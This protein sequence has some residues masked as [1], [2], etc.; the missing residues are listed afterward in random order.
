MAAVVAWCLQRCNVARALTALGLIISLGVADRS[1]DAAGPLHTGTSNDTIRVSLDR[2]KLIKVPEET[3]TLVVGNP[4]IAD[5]SV[6]SSGVVVITGKSYGATNVIALDSAGA[7]LVENSVEVVGPDGNLVLVYRGVERESYSCTP[8]C[9]RRITLGDTANYF[10]ATLGQ[11]GNRNTQAK[12]A[13]QA[14]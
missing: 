11:A 9:E 3:A 2:A 14:K 13:P 5:V 6:Q 7:V 4:L 12:S 10:N 8:E 1:A